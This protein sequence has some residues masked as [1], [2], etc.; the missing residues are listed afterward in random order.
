[1]YDGELKKFWNEERI[2]Y[3]IAAAEN[4]RFPE[5]IGQKA[6]SY[7]PAGSHICE[8][9]CGLGYLALTMAKYLNKVTAADADPDALKV[10][11]SNIEKLKAAGAYLRD[12]ECGS[13][14]RQIETVCCNVFEMPDELKYDGMVSQSFGGMAAS[15]EW[16]K[17]HGC[18]R[19]VIIR[20][21]WDGS[22]FTAV[23]SAENH[24]KYEDDLKCLE[25]TDLSYHIDRFKV[26]MGQPFKSLEDAVNFH[27]IYNKKIKEGEEEK[28]IKANL[29][30]CDM[31]GYPLFMP[32]KRELAFIVFENG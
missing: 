19:A 7:F 30:E 5:I 27:R 2:R 32:L 17:K 9:G 20:K 10:L 1:M 26:E 11:E 22:T 25:D 29:V 24:I 3:M 14:E 28:A 31:D 6:A 13:G 23:G 15:I 21:N 18:K 16:I 8:I 4:V 12:P